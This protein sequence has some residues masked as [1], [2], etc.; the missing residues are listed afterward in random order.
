VGETLITSQT[1]RKVAAIRRLRGRRERE[2]TG[3][4]LAEGIR[5]VVEAVQLGADIETLIVAPELL[6]SDLGRDLVLSRRAA[7]AACLEVSA[8][9]FASL[10]GKDGP[11]GLAAVIRQR[12]ASLTE[13]DGEQAV[14]D[15]VPSGPV[16]AD[17]AHANPA[18]AD[19]ALWV[20]LESVQDP[21][22]LGTIIRTSDAAGGRG[23]ILLGDGTDPHDPAGVRASMGSLF[24][25][26]IA[27]TS[28]SGLTA[29]ARRCGATLIAASGQADL[30]YDAPDLGPAYSG[31]VV[32]FLG[33]ERSGLL[34]EQVAVCDQA[35]KIPMAGRCDS[36]NLAVAA[37]VLL[38]EIRRRRRS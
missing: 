10:S 4:F 7:G 2:A 21:G 23:V 33:S 28:L 25:Q 1:N 8:P 35:V 5:I 6:R 11:Q 31:P 3:L 38:F 24:S 32:L 12:W 22:N 13:A 34:A 29:W 26:R 20:A 15:V 16:G 14:P 30:A 27:K 17:P 37:G 36:L 9:V 18:E 19:P